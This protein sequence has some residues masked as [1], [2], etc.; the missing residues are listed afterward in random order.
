MKKKPFF[1]RLCAGMLAALLLAGC[2]AEELTDK[3]A[4]PVV[5]NETISADSKWINSTIDGSIDAATPVN[6]K[7]DFYTAVNKDW[8]LEPLDEG[9][10][11]RSR[12]TVTQA[13]LDENLYQ[14]M[15]MDP[16]DV[17]G[18]DESIMSEETL[19]HL[20]ELVSTVVGYGKD[21]DT[22]NAQGAEPLRPY[23]EKITGISTMEE[24]TDYLCN[25]DGTN[26]FSLQ[27]APAQLIVSADMGST[28][29]V[30]I[31][32]EVTLSLRDE[33]QYTN[34]DNEGTYYY[35][36]N[37]DLM[38]YV[39]GQ[40]GY[41]NQETDKLLRACYRFEAKLAR[42]VLDEA[43]YSNIE[44]L[45]EKDPIY[46]LDEVQAMAGNYPLKTILAA[47][48]LDGSNGYTVQLPA[49]LKDVGRLYTAG[50]LEDIKAYLLVNTV[51]KA[52]DLLDDT[53]HEKLQ[54]FNNRTGTPKDS[55]SSEPTNKNHPDYDQWKE[56]YTR[57]VDPYISDAWQQVYIGHFCS[58]KEKQ[59]VLEITHKIV[60]AVEQCIL[61]ADWLGEETRSAALDKLHNMGIHVLYPDELT[62]YSSLSFENCGNLVDIA[63]AAN[64]FS[65]RQEAELVN[66]S[67]EK[68]DWRLAQLG[69]VST[70]AFYFG[71]ANSINI[72]AGFL[73]DHYF[74][75]AD[76]SLEENLATLGSVVGHEI[77][78]GFDT[79]GSQ[80]DKN[81]AYRSWWKKADRLAFDLRANDLI[82]YYSGLSPVSRG[83][84]LDGKTVSGEAIADMGGV[85]CGMIIAAQTPG[86]DYDL[87]FRTYAGLWR[88]HSDYKTE[89]QR[90]G[91]EH[92]ASMLRTNVTLMQFE[93]FQKTYNIQPGD[94]M[95]LAAED[96]I[97]VW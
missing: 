22:R 2:S 73:S 55:G 92:P 33:G 84:F 26:L 19:L 70:D 62:D 24:L 75:N 46:S 53:A 29:I 54:A 35:G 16:T 28:Y 30:T 10:K 91:N 44:E 5:K 88:Q 21:A 9:E 81:G 69:T 18:L 8:L 41:S 64:Q 68:D 66:R 97:L 93:E 67:F 43:M 7:D 47:Y 4:K 45:A 31:G 42:C 12:F 20:Q 78:H 48:G 96:R 77:T 6:L 79:T 82:K 32:A 90:A 71:S 94:G 56:L 87:Y 25:T 58:S 23:L 57:Y 85:K 27:L 52:A 40:L 80:F 86:F 49:H 51:L 83:S 38:R 13:Q 17:S 36:C 61:N 11:D 95:Y 63:A 34:L 3:L 72:C 50:N 76:A 14:I 60:D 1:L 74:F 65:N 15:T 59:Q 37:Q 39:L 89:F